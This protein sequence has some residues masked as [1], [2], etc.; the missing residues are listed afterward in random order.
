MEHVR[1]LH[2]IPWK[3][4]FIFE[5]A[6]N[7]TEREAVKKQIETWTAENCTGQWLIGRASDLSINANPICD[8]PLTGRQYPVS[9][10]TIPSPLLIV[11]E[12]EDEAT[13]F[14]LVFDGV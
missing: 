3:H 5:T 8:M 6:D 10:V 11:F 4:I 7:Y 14:K 12:K 13:A 9:V 2:C 1:T